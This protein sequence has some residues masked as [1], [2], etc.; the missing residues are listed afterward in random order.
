MGGG[1]VRER[2]RG[3]SREA[4]ESNTWTPPLP[5]NMRARKQNGV[6]TE[7]ETDRRKHRCRQTELQTIDFKYVTYSIKN[8]KKVNQNTILKHC[9][10][11]WMLC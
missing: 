9:C 4:R 7:R 3:G 8:L 11:N 1:R 2:N 6:R 5:R 10:G